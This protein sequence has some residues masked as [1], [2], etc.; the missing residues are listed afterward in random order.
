MTPERVVDQGDFSIQPPSPPLF[1]CQH[2]LV[3]PSI[4]TQFVTKVTEVSVKIAK[5]VKGT[6]K[7]ATLSTDVP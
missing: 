3:L 5:L 7:L 4:V 2:M 6:S 1:S